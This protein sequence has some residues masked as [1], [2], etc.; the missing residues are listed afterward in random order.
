MHSTVTVGSAT[1]VLCTRHSV[2][3]MAATAGSTP[4]GHMDNAALPT[5]Q[6]SQAATGAIQ[7]SAL[8]QPPFKLLN[9]HNE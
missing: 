4:V 8:G 1:H 2:M 3:L 5:T 7:P 9:K 6:D